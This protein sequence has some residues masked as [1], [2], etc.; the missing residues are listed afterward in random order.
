MAKIVWTEPALQDLDTIAE[1]IA[2]DKPSAASRFV[3]KVLSKI[4]RLELFPN[5]GKKVRELPEFSYREIIIPPVRIIYRVSEYRIFIIHVVR[6]E[7]DV[8]NFMLNP[9]NQEPCG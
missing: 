5:L 9:K 8:R 3:G 7:R 6:S 4:D 1:Y 2:L